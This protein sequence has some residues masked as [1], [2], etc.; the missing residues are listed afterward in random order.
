MTDAGR[1]FDEARLSKLREAMSDAELK[2]LDARYKADRNSLREDEVGVL[3]V[4]T[5][6][7]MR[8]FEKWAAQPL[9][10]GDGPKDPTSA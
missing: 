10:G 1:K 8:E 6:E 4:W 2:S 7:K 3:Y 5:R 9:G